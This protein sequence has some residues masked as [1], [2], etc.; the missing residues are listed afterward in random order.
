MLDEIFTLMYYL[1][2]SY[3][4]SYQLPIFKRKWFI[5]RF[6]KEVTPKDDNANVPV[7]ATHLQ[8][9]ETNIFKSASRTFSPN[10][11]NRPI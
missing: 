8:S 5:K 1:G 9:P 10:R 7:K 11:L 3:C 2:F 6:I 4:D